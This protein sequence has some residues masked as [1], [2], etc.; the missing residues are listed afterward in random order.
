MHTQTPSM[1]VDEGAIPLPE[2]FKWG[3]EWVALRIWRELR[4]DGEFIFAACLRKYGPNDFG[5]KSEDHIYIGREIKW[6]GERITDENKRSKTFGKRV[7]AKADTITERVFDDDLQEWKEIEIP[8]NATKT[9]EYLHKADDAE[10]VKLYKTLIGATPRSGKTH[11]SFIWAY[12]SEMREIK[13]KN[14]FFDHTVKELADWED[15]NA[16][17]EAFKK[18]KP[19]E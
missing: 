5:N 7:D 15:E 16:Q 1:I 10:F 3:K 12:G 11:M 18:S 6:I 14:E 9:Y 17:T 19:K 2:D 4:D 8:I 13:N